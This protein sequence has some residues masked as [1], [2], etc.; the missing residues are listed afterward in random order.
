MLHDMTNF[1]VVQ[2]MDVKEWAHTDGLT[3]GEF[4]QFLW[5]T[6]QSLGCTDPPQYSYREFYEDGMPKCEMH[7][8]I[9][10]PPPEEGFRCFRVM[11]VELWDTCQKAAR[12]ALKTICKEQEDNIDGTHAKYFPVKDQ[13][14]K[15]W[16][17]KLHEME[18]TSPQDPKFTLKLTAAYLTVME[19]IYNHQELVLAITNVKRKKAE[20]EVKEL[21]KE[22][23]EK[24]AQQMD[25]EVVLEKCQKKL[26]EALT[27]LKRRQKRRKRY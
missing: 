17:K 21:K 2:Q 3:V 4:A 24:S 27:K 5:V 19:K 26:Q 1:C 20:A 25:Q 12:K 18:H 9:K 16:R 6:L 10:R 8:H 7:L 13:T 22:M 11:G 23:Q 14:S 15:I